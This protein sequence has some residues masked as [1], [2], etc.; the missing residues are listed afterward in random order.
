LADLVAKRVKGASLWDLCTGSGV[1]GIAL[2]KAAP[3]LM[4]T[5]SDIDPAVLS[6]AEENARLN[7]VEI[8]GVA[9]DLLAPF[10][11][12]KVDAVVCNPPY[13]SAKEYLDLDPSVR[14]YEPKQALVGGERGT[15]FYER[16][17]EEL[18]SHL[19]PGGQLFLEI[20]A[21]QGE[22]VKK[23]FNKEPWK[24][25]ELIQDWSGKNRFFFLEKQ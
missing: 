9:G 3:R 7:G 16:L 20:G 11:G 18:P 21:S 8:E 25:G 17:A 2:K 4:V 23:I 12:R 15:E 24:N 1:L 14:D 19:E 22:V 10:E 5:L 13:I 6:L